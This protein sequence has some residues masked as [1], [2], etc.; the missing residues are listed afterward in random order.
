MN[1]MRKGFSFVE[2]M[3]W[4][5]YTSNNPVKYTDPDGRS[6][7]W[8]KMSDTEIQYH[9]EQ[10]IARDEYFAKSEAGSAG[11]KNAQIQ[12]S[13]I[14]RNIGQ[15]SFEKAKSSGQF[16]YEPATVL[17]LGID[18][19]TDWVNEGG[20][21]PDKVTVLG[22]EVKTST[23]VGLFELSLGTASVVQAK[24]TFE[25]T[26]GLGSVKAARQAVLG[27][28]LGILGISTMAS[29]E[30]LPIEQVLTTAEVGLFK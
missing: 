15:D 22:I 28:R 27:I 17:D 26:Q 5:S 23:A 9:V 29:G 21:L 7:K 3:N 14:L 4:Y 25:K 19:L 2:S 20:E 10:R 8:W 12:A 11:D 24:H 13:D 6:Q 16:N 18:E 1:P 30:V